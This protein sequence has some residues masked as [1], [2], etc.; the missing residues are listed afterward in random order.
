VHDRYRQTTYDRRTGD[1]I[2]EREREFTF[3]KN[4]W[5]NKPDHRC[6]RLTINHKHLYNFIKLI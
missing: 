1:S 2:I 5:L 6:T 3:A 4:Y